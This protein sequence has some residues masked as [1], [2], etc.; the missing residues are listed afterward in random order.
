MM[1]NFPMDAMPPFAKQ[2]FLSDLKDG[3][4]DAKSRYNITDTV[5][6]DIADA[7]TGEVMETVSQ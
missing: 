1:N 4:R 3:I 5:V 6:V 2:K 7:L